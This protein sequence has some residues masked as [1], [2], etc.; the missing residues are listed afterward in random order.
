[1]EPFAACPRCGSSTARRVSFTL[2]GGILGPA[3]FTHVR[4]GACG[5]TYNGK[6]GRFN[7]L[8]ITIYS[9]VGILLGIALAALLVMML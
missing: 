6:T 8:P 9:I 1:M 7:T 3:L 2:W 4:C 5:C